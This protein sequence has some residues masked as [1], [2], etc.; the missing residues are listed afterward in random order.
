MK[1][2]APGPSLAVDLNADLG[3]GGP[4]DTALLAVISSANVACGG[5][6]GDAQTMRETVVRARTHGVAVGAHPGYPDRAG[7]GRRIVPIPPGELTD[8]LASQIRALKEI[9]DGE[10]VRLQ[11]VKAHGALYNLAVADN[12]TADVIGRAMV[13]VDPGLIAV[14]LAG[15]PMADAFIRLGLRVVREAFIDRGYTA[16][17]T[18]VPRDQP[19]ALIT[20]PDQA[21][22]R[23]VRMICEGR[24]LAVDGREVAVE[25][26]TL[27]LH[28]DTPNSPAIAAASRRALEAAGIRVAPMGA[29][30]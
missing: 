19:G 5:H 24:I 30:P 18:L 20:D 26:Q 28:A 9:A 17:G 29:G 11:H 14:A 3:E 1:A 15:T 22:Q 12:A 25:A 13:Q 8:V 10:G 16:R 21:A 4:S 2:A 7:F 6:A 23:A 27:C